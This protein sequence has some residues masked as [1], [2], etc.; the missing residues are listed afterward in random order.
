MVGEDVS[1]AAGVV[2]ARVQPRQPEH[3]PGHSQQPSRKMDRHN[4]T[5]FHCRLRRQH[6]KGSQQ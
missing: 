6:I 3:K 1:G 4:P 5:R 2:E